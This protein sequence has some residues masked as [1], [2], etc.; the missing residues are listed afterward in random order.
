MKFHTFDLNHIKKNYMKNI[1]A[2]LGILLSVSIFSC[3]KDEVDNVID[4]LEPSF[5]SRLY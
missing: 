5:Y 2:V 4:P 3:E 1:F